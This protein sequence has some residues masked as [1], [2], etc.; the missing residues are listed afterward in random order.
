MELS[1]A[2]DMDDSLGDYVQNLSAQ[3]GRDWIGQRDA[4]VL[5]Q[6]EKRGLGL[7]DLPALKGRLFRCRLKDGTETWQLDDDP[8]VTF[9][10]TESFVTDRH[11]TLSSNYY[12]R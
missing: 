6:L 12:I 5:G 8:L 3:L 2:S 4:I 7:A 1:Y 11:F 10:P 9:L